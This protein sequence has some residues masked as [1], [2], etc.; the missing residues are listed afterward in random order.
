MSDFMQQEPELDGIEGAAGDDHVRSGGSN[1][2]TSI[3]HGSEDHNSSGISMVG[4]PD[5]DPDTKSDY[6][7]GTEAKD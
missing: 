3:P 7:S 2:Q 5:D 1:G 4:P 6:F